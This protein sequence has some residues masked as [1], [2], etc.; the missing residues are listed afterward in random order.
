M[1]RAVARSSG[2]T[3]ASVVASPLPPKSSAK[4]RRTASSYRIGYSGTRSVM[5]IGIIWHISGRPNLQHSPHCLARTVGDQGIH[6][7]YVLHRPQGIQDLGQRY[8]FHVRAEIAGTDKFDLGKFHGDVVAHGA[9]CDHQH[10]L[11]SAFADFVDHAGRRSH[12]I[13]FGQHVGRAFRM[14]KN[15]DAGE[16][17]PVG[18]KVFG[19]E[20]LVNFAMAFPEYDF[21]FGL[22]GDVA[23]EKFIRQKNDAIGVQRLY[24]LERIA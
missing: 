5:L 3:I 20:L 23:A 12:V 24:D 19:R 16:T 6:F 18:A 8:Q 1:M 9:F 17:L 10:A 21:F 22:T 11:R 4:A 13:G 2:E 15:H 14:G 7:H